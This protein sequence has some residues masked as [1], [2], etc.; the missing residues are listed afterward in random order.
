MDAASALPVLALDIQDG[1]HV[2]DYC[3]A[4]GGKALLMYLTLKDCQ[5]DLNDI[6]ISRSYRLETVFNSFIPRS[7]NRK[8]NFTRMDATK[9]IR[10][11]TYDRILVDVPCTNDR[12][13]LYAS[14]N[15]I[16][17]RTR[18]NE[19]IGIPTKQMN[20]LLAALNSVKVGGTVVYS[21]CS[22]SPIQNDGVIHMALKT[23]LERQH[24]SFA[25]VNMKESMRPFRGLFRFNHYFR[26][27]TQVVP[28]LCSNYGPM[29]FA[30]FIRTG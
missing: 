29:Y 3:A 21:T 15:N 1:N 13:S 25:V 27:G 24:H 23:I 8:I 20:I 9:L 18:I 22:L 2:A 26:Y 12:H 19:R 5:F 6:S 16:F 10:P 14:D 30:K 4:P 28:F 11:N 7:S 17:S